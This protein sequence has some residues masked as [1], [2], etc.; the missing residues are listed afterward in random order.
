MRSN[1][2]QFN[3]LEINYQMLELRI[4]NLVK[5]IGTAFYWYC[6]Q[7]L[8]IFLDVFYAIYIIFTRHKVPRPFV[9]KANLPEFELGLEVVL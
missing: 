2:I 4:C 3:V 9:L 6:R 8:S 5:S 1:S 7:R